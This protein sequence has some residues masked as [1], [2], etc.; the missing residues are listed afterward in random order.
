MNSVTLPAM[1]CAFIVIG[2][3]LGKLQSTCFCGV[4]TPWTLA[5]ELSWNKTHRMSGRLMFAVGA[6]TALLPLAPISPALSWGVFVAGTLLIVIAPVAY[7]YRIW[8][9]DPEKRDVRKPSRR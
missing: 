9:Q 6:V 1:G 2:N 7:S 3:Y 5:S 4:R 8:K